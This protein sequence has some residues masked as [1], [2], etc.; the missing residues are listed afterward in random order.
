MIRV[1]IEFRPNTDHETPVQ[2]VHVI[3]HFLRVRVTRLVKLVASPLVILPVLPV[4]DDVV[5]G[6]IPAPE[7]GQRAHKIFLS[8]VTLAALPES[9]RPFR[10]HLSLSG[11][12]SV[13]GDHLVHIVSGDIIIV[14]F[15]THLRPERETALL[16]LGPWLSHS[17]SD[18]RDIPIRPPADFDR[19][20]LALLKADSE[21]VGVR[22]PCRSP[23]LGDNLFAV[24]RDALE[25]SV[26]KNE[27]IVSVL[28]SLD[29]AFVG[30]VRA[31][32]RHFRKIRD[33]PFILIV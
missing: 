18:V 6:N 29:E 4:L 23:T 5:H 26:I 12:G 30:H 3:E 19:S 28:R 14:Q 21:F 24:Y 32:K 27:M 17:Q 9:K 2:G 15:R 16:G 10:H 22:I 8:A 1:D 25:A 20:L 7:L 33:N 13:A 31:F 11:E